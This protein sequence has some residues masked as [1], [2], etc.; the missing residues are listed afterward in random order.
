ML[1]KYK[2]L[3]SLLTAVCIS[4]GVVQPVLAT[5][6]VPAYEGEIISDYSNINEDAEEELTD[7]EQLALDYINNNPII[8]FPDELEGE[9]SVASLDTNVEIASTEDEFVVGAV[10]SV[11][12][13]ANTN[14]DSVSQT[15]GALTYEK[16][17]L[18]LP[19]VNGL[20]LEI[21][22]KYNSQ[23]AVVA[24]NEFFDETDGVRKI[25][26]N[27]FAAGWSFAFPT[28]TKQTV[29]KYGWK[30]ED[31]CLS[32]PDGSSY[33]VRYDSDGID[34]D[35]I[36][37]LKGYKLS[38]MELVRK[39]DTK[40]Y[41]LTYTD[42]RVY[43][44]DGE[45][46]NIKKISDRYGNEINFSYTEIEYSRGSFTDYIFKLSYYNAKLNA[47]TEIRDSAGRV[48]TIDYDVKRT[49]NGNEIKNIKISLAGEIYS[50]MNLDSKDTINGMAYFVSSVVDGEG[51]KTEYKYDDKISDIYYCIDGYNYNYAVNGNIICLEEVKL[52]TG[53]AVYYEYEKYRRKYSSDSKEYYEVYKISKTGDSSGF[54]RTYEY[55]ND[56]SG[57]PYSY[58]DNDE[59]TVNDS[60]F[61]Y[62]CIIREGDLTTISSFDNKHNKIYENT[63]DSS[64]SQNEYYAGY[65]KT[66]WQVMVGTWIYHF[67]FRNVDGEG[68]DWKKLVLYKTNVKTGEIEILP[69]P[70]DPIPKDAVIKSV[71]NKIYIMYRK[72]Y[73]NSTE[74]YVLVAKEYN[75]SADK[76]YEDEC[77]ELSESNA[78]RYRLDNI[79][80]VDSCFVAWI[81]EQEYIYFTIYDTYAESGSKWR[82]DNVESRLGSDFCGIGNINSKLYFSLKEYIYEYDVQNN[83]FSFKSISGL[84]SNYKRFGYIVG[85]RMYVVDYDGVIYEIDYE[86]GEKVGE[87]YSD[88]YNNKSYSV[89]KATD[90]NVY[91]IIK[92]REPDGL[93]NIYRFDPCNSEDKFVYISSRLI[94]NTTTNIFAYGTASKPELCLVSDGIERIKLYEPSKPQ[95][96]SRTGYSY[97]SYN[98]PTQINR[99]R[100]NG[101][102]TADGGS[103]SYT[104][105]DKKSIIQ[106][107]TDI[108]GNKTLYEYSDSTYYIPTR[109]TQYHGTDDELITHNTLSADGKKIVLSETQHSDTCLKVEYR[110]EDLNCPGNVTSELLYEKESGKYTLVSQTDYS[111][112]SENGLVKDVTKRNI[113]TN[114]AE[115][116]KEAL[117]DITEYYYYDALGRVNVYADPLGRT[118]EYYYNKNG[119]QTEVL[120]NDGSSTEFIYKLEG[121]KGGENAIT[122]VYNNRCEVTDYFNG[123]GM[124]TKRYENPVGGEKQL[125]YEYKYDGHNIIRKTTS[126]TGYINYIYDAANRVTYIEK[127]YD[128]CA[129]FEY[130]EAVYD[131]FNN[132][133]TVFRNSQQ[134]SKSY[135]DNAGRIV[136]KESQTDAGLAVVENYYDHMGNVSKTVS[137]DGD[138]TQYSYNSRGLLESVQDP[139]GGIVSYTYDAMGN[140]LTVTNNGQVIT[141]N[142]YDNA[143][144]VLSVTDAL[145]TSERYQYDKCGRVVKSVDRNGVVTNNTYELVTDYL[146]KQVKGEEITEYT[147]D[148]SGNV[149]TA[150]NGDGTYEYSYTFNNMLQSV[151]APDGKEISYSYD[152]HHNL[153]E[154][155]DYSGDVIGYEYDEFDRVIG[156]KRNDIP[157]ARY[158]YT[159]LNNIG[160]IKYPGQGRTSFYY[161]RAGRLISQFNTL[162]NGIRTNSYSYEYDL[163]GNR[164]REIDNGNVTEYTYDAL[165]R[166]TGVTEPDGTITSYTFDTQG[167]IGTKTVEHPEG[168]EFTFTQG[169]EEYTLDDVVTHEFTYAY[170][171]NNRLKFEGEYIGGSGD[172]Y[173]GFLE[174]TKYNEYDNNGNLL[175][176]EKGG[177]I[178]DSVVSYGYNAYNRQTSYT[179]EEGNT[180]SY[181]CTPDGLRSSKTQNGVTTKFYWD[182]GYIS[183]ES[184][185]GNISAKNYVGINGIFA[186]EA[187]NIT[188]YMLKNGHS[189]VV[190]LVRNGEVVKTYDYDAYGVQ[191]NID[192][193]DTNPFRYCGEYFDK[194]SGSIYLRAR[195]YF[196]E[197]GRFT[198]MDKHWNVNNMIYGDNA[199]SSIVDYSAIV[200]SSNLYIYG[201]NNPVTNSDFTGELTPPGKIHNWVLKDI[202][203]KNG[204]KLSKERWVA[205]PSLRSGRVDLVDVTSGK[206][207]ELKPETWSM[208]DAIKQLKMY[209]TGR[210]KAKELQGFDVEIG[211]NTEYIL[212]GSFDRDIY[213]VEYK[214]ARDGV[215]TYTYSINEAELTR[216][217]EYIG[218]KMKEGTETAAKIALAAFLLG[219]SIYGV[220]VF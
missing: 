184:V 68:S 156:I 16:K 162:E 84:Y 91:Y 167:N 157:I 74:P 12:N 160:V 76:W 104:Y 35:T 15:T 58:T 90:G 27:S 45:Y 150:S 31:T 140:P 141:T 186:R 216:E 130:T 112:F 154:V 52:P 40:D 38:D 34:S 206:I 131:D 198:T 119:W 23:D 98:Q 59:G 117:T 2:R 95:S 72:G 88:I 113:L 145:G 123:L 93:S 101:T 44:F 182:R 144:R 155:V 139:M 142:T 11:Y 47:L 163:N 148:V 65:G 161:D 87:Y 179:D 86:A 220:P 89:Q 39:A 20:D 62:H 50:V 94:N 28:I 172:D 43:V 195:Y 48:I 66:Q 203:S 126:E 109:I 14:N 79:C 106:S 175:K 187:N 137:P 153:I 178:D 116:E 77:L 174:I 143:G 188:D 170:D 99:T 133:Q 108:L 120:K 17:L 118:T 30:K 121:A 173:A 64:N 6:N 69:V 189:D 158:G 25:N 159:T 67:D 169:G 122:T 100:I 4:L 32:F 85:N 132:T 97:N 33:T 81:K 185:N 75:T 146:E 134:E 211:D 193:T 10:N 60:T 83:T 217:L 9:M 204:G 22:V 136:K 210:F 152:A 56:Y 209:T 151:K 53:G 61:E 24:K 46:G 19:G 180:T 171:K 82:C 164:I 165:N 196:P 80:F 41:E 73:G 212:N 191:K 63:Y 114:N 70:D 1:N 124:Q 215:I 128:E 200:Q 78:G 110:Y 21:S 218:V 92:E 8:S 129:V 5:E 149:L 181:T 49:I 3:I 13:V 127:L 190:S 207:W 138:E 51:Y 214:Y 199:G 111:Y 219:A 205:L 176:S 36:L 103:E 202:V 71:G 201:L 107:H 29:E 54:S 7:E 135:F 192:P 18:S 115:F 125:L 213:H 177:Q 57:Y 37:K 166:L 26:F 197:I 42:G 194:E 168:Y 96:T 208:D 183:A 55:E 105:V 102:K 147:Y